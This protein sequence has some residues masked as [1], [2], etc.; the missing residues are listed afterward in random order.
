[1]PSPPLYRVGKGKSALYLKDEEEFKNHILKK[2][3][4]QRQIEI[5][6][7]EKPIK[8]HSLY[9]FVGNLSEYVEN[10]E[11]LNSRGIDEKLVSLMVNEGVV[12]SA[13]L[14]NEEKMRNLREKLIGEKY[15]VSELTWNPDRN[16][17]NLYVTYE[18]T[19][20]N[21]GYSSSK[22]ARRWFIQKN[23]K[24]LSC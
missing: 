11:K 4:D 21:N 8:D 14:Q 24:T 22:S 23:S 17:Y 2:V 1:M 6:G 10:M 16:V 12:D 9:I 18:E 19:E 5:A 20:E 7:Q 13:F 15:K 3:C